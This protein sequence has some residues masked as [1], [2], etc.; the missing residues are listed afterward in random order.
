MNRYAGAPQGQVA[1]GWV[2]GME[3]CAHMLAWGMLQPS[4]GGATVRA[5]D[6]LTA[7][8]EA[9]PNE[10]GVMEPVHF[11]ASGSHVQT[12][13]GGTSTE[14]LTYDWDF[15]DGTTGTGKDPYHRYAAE[16]TYQSKLTVTNTANGQTATMEVPIV[17]QAVPAIPLPIPA[18]VAP[19]TDEDGT[20]D[21]GYSVGDT[22]SN[23]QGWQILEASDYKR[24]LAD[25][26]E[27]PIETKWTPSEPTHADIEP[28][29]ASDSDTEKFR[30]NVSS[31]GERSY[32][33]GVA[34]ENFKPGV[35]QQGE[36]I[37][38][39]KEPL[40]V[41]QEA[42]SALSYNSL[43]LNESDDRGMVQVAE[44]KD[45]DLNWETVDLMGGQNDTCNPSDPANTLLKELAPRGADLTNYAGKRIFVRFVYQTGETNPAASQPCGWYID[46]VEIAGGTFKPVD[47][48]NQIADVGQFFEG[49]YT[50]RGRQKGLYAYRVRGLY[51]PGGEYEGPASNIRVVD[52]TKGANPPAPPGGDP[53]RTDPPQPPRVETCPFAP[54]FRTA[55]A[56]RR[57]RGLAFDF[58]TLTGQPARIDVFQASRGTR[59]FRARRVARFA[60]RT[61][62]FAWNGRSRRRLTNGFYFARFMTGTA[63]DHD[64]R[65]VTLQRSKGRFRIVRPHYRRSTC[66]VLRTFKL[67]S[68]AFGG[69]N[70]KRLGVAY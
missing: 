40:Q 38:T 63:E 18:L 30:G 13:G 4:Q 35:I 61:R 37:L 56:T 3:M 41:P 34:T 65:R 19:E 29:Q 64:I 58:S 17:V 47:R 28:W 53:P 10:A 39:L 46:D 42:G 32:W 49:T 21:I 8:Y 48:S 20:F 44:A 59:V 7:Y 55:K 12:A 24:L 5:A 26:A 62:S 6:T 60:G 67:S 9:L 23:L 1:E 36:S 50:V 22:P 27:G 54:K 25:D 70:R 45:G 69:R 57:G 51:P 52:V 16:G 66:G 14:G 15:G 33:T 68:P 31:S 11:D 2:K 43:F